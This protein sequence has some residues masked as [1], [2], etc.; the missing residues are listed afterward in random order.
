MKILRYR[1]DGEVSYGIL[2]EGGRIRQL[3]ASP[4]DSLD[5][6]GT[7]AHL[8]Q[9]TVLAPVENPRI[10]GVGLNYAAHARE[11][12]KEPPAFPMLFMKPTL[13]AIGPEEPIIYPHQGKEVHYECELAVIIGKQTR[14]VLEAAALDYVLGYTCGNDISERVIQFAEMEMGC[15]LLGKGFDTFC[16]LGPVIATGLDPTNLD[17]K[18]RLNGEVKQ[19]SNTADLLFSVAHLVSYISAVMTLLPGDVIMTGTPSGV[20]PIAPGDTVEIEISGVGVLR[21][22]VVAE[23]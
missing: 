21:N 22:P 16:P 1:S 19:D 2:D 11:A 10:I 23:V 20:G 4:F 5:T 17:I 18:T 15:M 13:T 9:V 3:V 14:R 12:G 6:N 8:D 7:V